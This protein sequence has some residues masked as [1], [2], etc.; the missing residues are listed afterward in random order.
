LLAHEPASLLAPFWV[1]GGALDARLHPHLLPTA[2]SESAQ[3]SRPAASVPHR[4]RAVVL[5]VFCAYTAFLVATLAFLEAVHDLSLARLMHSYPQL[6]VPWMV[7]AAAAAV[8]LAA[9]VIGGLPIL[10]AVCKDAHM[11]RRSD[12]WL[13]AVLPLTAALL[14]G[15]NACEELLRGPHGTLS[16]MLRLT[17]DV[18]FYAAC[19]VAAALCTAAVCVPVLRSTVG[20][21]HYRF[22]LAPAAIVTVAMGTMLGASIVWLV[23]ASADAPKRFGTYPYRGRLRAAGPAD[24]GCH[25]PGKRCRRTRTRRR[26]RCWPR[27]TDDGLV[28]MRL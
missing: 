20:V 14:A 8:A 13:F 27:R 4:L 21:R 24:G 11:A 12:V 3:G 7:L 18:L 19:V 10:V 15:C 26:H 28:A 25:T 6:T 5:T 16:A 17:F 9:V 2:S 22:A 23:Q 1:V